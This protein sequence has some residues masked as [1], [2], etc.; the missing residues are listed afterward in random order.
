[1]IGHDAHAA[2]FSSSIKDDRTDRLS[3][4]AIRYA[5]RIP[6]KNESTTEASDVSDEASTWHAQTPKQRYGSAPEKG[7]DVIVTPANK[8]AFFCSDRRIKVKRSD[9]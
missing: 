3:F 4:D 8:L 5:R 1:M 6:P 7:F 9:L 2:T